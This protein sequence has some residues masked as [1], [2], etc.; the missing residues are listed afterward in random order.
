MKHEECFQL[1]TILKRIGSEG[2]LDIFIDSDDPEKYKS[3][4]AVFIDLH[5]K[6]VPFFL[7]SFRMHG[8]NN[9]FIH[10]E[11]VTSL[12]QAEVLV[13][14]GIYLPLEQLPELSGKQFYFHEVIGFFVVDANSN[15]SIGEIIDVLENGPNTLLNLQQN[16]EE[17]LIPLVREW[18][19]TIDRSSKVI[20]MDL[21]DGLIK[22]NAKNKPQP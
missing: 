8:K 13:G 14:S 17:I 3:T 9:A 19:Q 22:L 5:G 15:N 4:T 21:P 1:G 11:D 18:I 7:T 6:L 16:H 10:L 20:R 2:R 12:E